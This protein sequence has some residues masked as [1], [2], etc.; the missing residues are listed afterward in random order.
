MSYSSITICRDY[1]IRLSPTAAWK[2]DIHFTGAAHHFIRYKECNESDRRGLY[3]LEFFKQHMLSLASTIYH[4]GG[5]EFAKDVSCKGMD[6]RGNWNP[7]VLIEK[8]MKMPHSQMFDKMTADPDYP[9]GMY[10]T[11]YDK[12][13]RNLDDLLPAVGRSSVS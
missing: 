4:H 7:N 2:V 1:G 6:V 11:D 5:F 10:E 12:H 3:H 8:L 13:L 9:V